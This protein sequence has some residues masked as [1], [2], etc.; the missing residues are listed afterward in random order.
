MLTE[1]ASG[2][3]VRRL[4]MRSRALAGVAGV[5][6]LVVTLARADQG[7]GASCLAFGPPGQP[8]AETA[9][10]PHGCCD[11]GRAGRDTLLGAEA[12]CSCAVNAPA[13]RVT[14]APRLTEL[15]PPQLSETPVDRGA[16]EAPG[17]P[18]RV[19]RVLGAGSPSPPAT[20][21]FLATTALLI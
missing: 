1:R 3:R 14:T 12:P 16:R 7:L 4:V 2:S 20:Q 5:V 19:R 17:S 15:R 8:C 18:S 13:E 9:N 10:A 21:R 6:L 11:E